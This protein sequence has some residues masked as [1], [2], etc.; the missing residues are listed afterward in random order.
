V[1]VEDP[2]IQLAGVRDVGLQLLELRRLEEL[3]RPA[4]RAADQRVREKENEEPDAAA[5]HASGLAASDR[6]CQERRRRRVAAVSV[7]RRGADFEARAYIAP[8]PIPLDEELDPTPPELMP[9]PD[10]APEL[11]PD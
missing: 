11:S 10:V 8:P 9:P 6:G 4:L 1:L 7:S 2:L 3:G 5:S